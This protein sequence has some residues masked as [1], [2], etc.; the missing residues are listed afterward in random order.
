MAKKLG[1]SLSAYRDMEIGKTII[2]NPT[3][4]KA[5]ETIGADPKEFFGNQ[6]ICIIKESLTNLIDALS[7]ILKKIEE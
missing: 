5:A 1:I 6:S 2:V 7:I 4:L 3:F